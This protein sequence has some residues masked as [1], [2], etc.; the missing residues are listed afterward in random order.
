MPLKFRI[1]GIN[2]MKTNKTQ[3]APDSEAKAF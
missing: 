2:H 3:E 1:E